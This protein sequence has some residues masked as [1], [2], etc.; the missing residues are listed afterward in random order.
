M[1]P[2]VYHKKVQHMT[3]V[4]FGLSQKSTSLTALV[5]LQTLTSSRL[6]VFQYA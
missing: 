6:S 5:I 2:L 4:T 3:D 1:S